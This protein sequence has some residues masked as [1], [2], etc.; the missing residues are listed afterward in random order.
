[1]IRVGHLRGAAASV[2]E[3]DRER[4]AVLIIV[5]I[6]LAFLVV[7]TALTVDIG[8]LS[9]RRR[10]L[11]AVADVMS[12][13]LVRQLG[14][15]TAAT[16]VADPVWNNAI[17]DSRARNGFSPTADRT[18]AV[19]LGTYDA[20]TDV[21]TASLP[22]QVPKAVKV[23]TSDT[24]AFSFVRG[25]RRTSRSSVASQAEVGGFSIGSIGVALSSQ[26]STLLNGIIGDALDVSA[27]SYSGLAGAQ[28]HLPLLVQSLGLDLGDVDELLDHHL[29]LLQL[30]RAEANALRLGGDLA[31]A[32]LLDSLAV[33][34]PN[35]SLPI[36]LG[37]LLSIE[38]GGEAAAAVAS[39]D[40]LRLLTATALV[41]NGTNFLNLTDLGLSV[42]GLASASL[43][44]QVI[45]KPQFVFGPVGVHVDT[46]QVNLVTALH[47]GGTIAPG[48]TLSAL[49]SVVT[50][51][52]SGSGVISSIGCGAPKRMGI[53]VGTSL[54]S[55]TIDLTG[56]VQLLLP[57]ANIDLGLATTRSPKTGSVSFVV[58]PDA[59]G[60][61]KRYGAGEGIGLSGATI[62]R[63][64]TSIIGLTLLP[65][66]TIV[67]ATLTTVVNPV[68]AA[69]DQLLSGPLNS[70]LGLSL[71]DADVT[72]LAIT[73]AGPRLAA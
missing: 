73:C 25:S 33:A 64:D 47:V 48:A 6:C 3:R 46:A 2:A 44:L 5:S 60:S 41:A 11:Q 7:A 55:T 51:V 68:I 38:T 24:V 14:G 57:I 31:Q 52:A 1:M 34:L 45:E 39:I 50:K 37:D 16:I 30:V 28:V 42:P 22:S 8:R 59:I 65:V 40:A 43:S 27:I 69:L 62:T 21:F 10:D 26:E 9:A 13:D 23:T 54:V 4:G 20:R 49:T 58:P 15:R 36:T 53:G 66:S 67:N 29:T 18:V 35:P 17:D 32:T 61:A 71:S 70:V 72:P 12:L 19:S 56:T 63:N